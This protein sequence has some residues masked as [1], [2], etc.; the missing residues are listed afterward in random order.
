MLSFHEQDKIKEAVK[1]SIIDT[2]YTSLKQYYYT[3]SYSLVFFC[4]KREVFAIKGCK[5]C[6][7]CSKYNFGIVWNLKSQFHSF[8]NFEKTKKLIFSAKKKNKTIRGQNTTNI[9]G[10]RLSFICRNFNVL[11]LFAFLYMF[12]VSGEVLFLKLNPFLLSN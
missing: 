11:L 8:L 7:S 12:I 1:S 6:A 10:R 9:W 3:I 5:D 4:R 2:I